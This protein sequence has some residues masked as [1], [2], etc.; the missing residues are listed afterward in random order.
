MGL[1]QNTC[2]LPRPVCGRAH[3]SGQIGRVIPGFLHTDLQFDYPLRL[4]FYFRIGFDLHTCDFHGERL[5]NKMKSE[6]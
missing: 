6:S 4:D 5:V 2:L 3:V 1:L